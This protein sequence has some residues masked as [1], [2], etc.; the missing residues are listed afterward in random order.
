[1]KVNEVSF[2]PDDNRFYYTGSTSKSAVLEPHGENHVSVLCHL[3]TALSI[4]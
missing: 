4:Y 1:M 3:F 2:K